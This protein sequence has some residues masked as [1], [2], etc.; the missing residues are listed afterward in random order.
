MAEL[1]DLTALEQGALVRRGE[2]SPLELVDHYLERADRLDSVGAFVTLTPGPARSLDVY[3]VPIGA[4]RPR[5]AQLV[6]EL[7]RAGVRTDMAFDGR[8]LKGAMKGA[9]RSGAPMTIVLGERDLEHGVCQVKSMD[10][11]DQV[12]VPLDH[13][14]HHMMSMMSTGSI[15]EETQK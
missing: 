2:V 8:S 14:V 5:A 11:G 3:V 15:T 4:A 9:D 10:T 1:H 13:V 7:R 12:A 6:T